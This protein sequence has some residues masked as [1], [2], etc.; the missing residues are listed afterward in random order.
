M[1]G[2]I[3]WGPGLENVL[4]FERID[5]PASSRRLRAGSEQER[6]GAPGVED[7]WTVGY[8]EE[9]TGDLRWLGNDVWSGPSGAQ[10]FLDWAREK[11]TFRYV[12]D[13]IFPDFWVD[14]CYLGAPTDEGVAGALE[15]DDRRRLPVVI[16]N[17]GYDFSLA[18]RKLFMDYAPG[19]PLPTSWAYTATSKRHRRDGVPN[20]VKG[21]QLHEV[22]VG[23]LRDRD[24]LI[25]NNSDSRTNRLEGVGTNRLTFPED[26]TNAAWVKIGLTGVTG[27][28]IFAPT[29]AVAADKIIEDTGTSSHYVY[30]TLTIAAGSKVSFSVHLKAAQRTRALV[31]VSAGTGD[32]ADEFGADINLTTGAILSNHVAGLGA[33]TIA[34]TVQSSYSGWH[35]VL[36]QGIA[37]ASSTTVSVIIRLA[38]AGGNFTYTGD[39]TSGLYAWG[40]YAD[41]NEPPTSYPVGGASRAS[42]E[43]I[44]PWPWKP[45]P[46]WQYRKFIELGGAWKTVSQ[47]RCGTIGFA[48][49]A[50]TGLGNFNTVGRYSFERWNAAG[51]GL[52]AGMSVDAT[53][54]ATI[55]LLGLCRTDGKVELRWSINGGADGS[56]V[57]GSGTP[58]G[59]A[60]FDQL[61]NVGAQAGNIR[62]AHQ[63]LLVVKAG[64]DVDAVTTIAL[65]R[66]A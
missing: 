48:G 58:Y 50:R 46:F 37:D 28:F 19:M 1:S 64:R 45:Q 29:R 3:L 4:E 7:A 5:A 13:A 66:V 56:S 26:L 60:W 6:S 27:N 10:A 47:G 39:G 32:G 12:P 57:S 55:E 62:H 34:P 40:A 20:L 65:A 21:G 53:Y 24:Y 54:G 23:L 31:Y 22:G 41:E 42:E 36:F 38:D 15:P 14:G 8:D 63:G 35:R 2:R 16:R 44:V 9:L 49:M 52:G 43:L 17:P 11:K 59:D 33:L 25:S 30:Q 18:R 51:Q 61:Y